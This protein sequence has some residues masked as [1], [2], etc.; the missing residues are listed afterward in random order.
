MSLINSITLIKGD[1]S[2]IYSFNSPDFTDFTDVNWVGTWT[3]RDKSLTGTLI[4]SGSLTKTPDNT[5]FVF[6]LLPEESNIP[7]GKYFLSIE[8]SNLV[9]GFRREVVQCSLTIKQDGV[10]S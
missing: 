2:D 1:S 7:A 10:E 9:E 3:I 5:A 8:I 6:R 4:K